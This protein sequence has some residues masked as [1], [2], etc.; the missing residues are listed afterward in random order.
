MRYD[1]EHKQKT[2]ERILKAAARAVREDGPHRVS[3]AGVMQRAELTHGGFYAHFSSKD[4]LLAA[5]IG[6]MFE[7][8]RQRWLR[9]TADRSAAEGLAGFID[10]YLSATH[11]DARKL[12]CPIAALSA[13]LP[14]MPAACEAAF[15]EGCRQLMSR[16]EEKL[17]A[18]GVTDAG[19]QASSVLSELVGALSL[20]RCEPDR[21]RS[22][23]LLAASRHTLKQRLHLENF[24]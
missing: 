2:R 8:S 5:A 3:V 6:Q 15:A 14:R 20:S 18:L 1:S 10:H 16:I 21:A 7:D 9:S 23:A 24:T 17:S 4:D 13:D 12:G 11:R 19:I 22:D